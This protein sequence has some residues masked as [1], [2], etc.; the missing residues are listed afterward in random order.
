MVAGIFLNSSNSGETQTVLD[1]IPK[2]SVLVNLNER[3]DGSALK[4]NY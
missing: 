4:P 1:S 3:W 2:G